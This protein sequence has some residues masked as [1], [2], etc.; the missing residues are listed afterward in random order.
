[1]FAIWKKEMLSYFLSPIAYIFMGVFMVITGISFTLSNLYSLNAQFASTLGQMLYLFTLITPILTMRLFSEERKNKTDQLLLTSPVSLISVVLGK[2]FAALSVFI[3]TLMVSFFF[4]IILYMFGAPAFGELVLGYLGFFLLGST[5][6]AIG[7]F[8]SALT[9]NQ[10]TAAVATLGTFLMLMTGTGLT[11]SINIPWVISILEWIS[12]Y[13]R[14]Y[15]F[16]AGLL[17][18][19]PTVYYISF[20]ALFVFLTIRSIE[21][22]RWSES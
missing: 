22:R 11:S 12:I 20:C 21:K 19:T 9:E 14:F 18:L 6:I 7:M 10:V 17:S 2:Y 5:L 16:N 3:I 4:P 13:E 1:M 15:Y 8:I